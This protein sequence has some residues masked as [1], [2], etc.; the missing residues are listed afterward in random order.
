M[1]DAETQ[2]HAGPHP[3]GRPLGLVLIVG[4]KAIWGIVELT[5]GLA[6]LFSKRLIAIELAEDPQDLFINWLISHVHLDERTA[7]SAGVVLVV[8]A[9]I[10]LL[11]AV[12][13]WSRSW[14]FRNISLV[15]FSLV[16]VYGLYHLATKFTAANALALLADVFIVFYLWRILPKHL[17]DR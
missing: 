13:I 9:L 14:R 16:A 4:Y 11:L 8:L 6:L 12:G 2:E 7:I 15:F 10:K 5:A 17:R 3:F 1:N